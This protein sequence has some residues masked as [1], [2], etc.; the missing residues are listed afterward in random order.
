MVG[1]AIYKSAGC[2]RPQPQTRN[3][4]IQKSA[5]SSDSLRANVQAAHRTRVRAAARAHCCSRRLSPPSHGCPR[6]LCSPSPAHV[7]AY[8]REFGAARAPN[9]LL[10]SSVVPVCSLLHSHNHIVFQFVRHFYH[11]FTS[12]PHCADKSLAEAEPYVEVYRPY[13][14]FVL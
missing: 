12:K 9:R 6:C 11:V 4:Q 2:S 13:K 3:G 14:Y 8:V 10:L 1:A 5:V 7:L